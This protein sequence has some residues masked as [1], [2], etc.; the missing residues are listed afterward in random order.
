MKDAPPVP[1]EPF[2]IEV[3]HEPPPPPVHPVDDAENPPPVEK[4][5]PPP[6]PA[7]VLTVAPDVTAKVEVPPLPPGLEP[8]L[9]AAPP[10]PTV[11]VY[12]DAMPLEIVPV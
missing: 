7:E 9:L 6:P 5:D 3:A 12:D 10:P 1:V 11:M 8:E 2:E 4:D